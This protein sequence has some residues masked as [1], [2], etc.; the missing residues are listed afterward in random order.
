MPTPLERAIQPDQY[1]L[2][3]LTWKE[4]GQPGSMRA[5]LFWEY[6]EPYTQSWKG[7]RILDIGSGTGWLAQYALE[8]GAAR[9][10]GIDSSAHS[11]TQGKH[12]YPNIELQQTTFENFTA[13]EQSF[14]EILAI[15]SFSHISDLHGAFRKIHSF[16]STQG[17]AIIIVPDYDYFHTPH[18]NYTIEQ[19]PINEESYA[20]S[21]TRSWGTLADI[22]H[23]VDVYDRVASSMS[24][25]LIKREA[26]FPTEKQIA[27]DPRYA[28]FKH[29]A[30]A[31]LLIFERERS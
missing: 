12:D 10:L 22:V 1:D 25:Q 17:R 31:Q 5:Q 8:R 19:Q 3:D 9:A 26:I 24:L 14:D 29:V 27:R 16:L 23:K 18:H 21:I 20:V 30:L 28:D 13:T 15:M 4:S 6:L 2:H 11:I 7:K